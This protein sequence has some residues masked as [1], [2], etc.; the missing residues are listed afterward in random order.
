MGI[1]VVGGAAARVGSGSMTPAG[2]AAPL[3]RASAR[4]AVRRPAGVRSEI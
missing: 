4:A 1:F 2:A 3:A